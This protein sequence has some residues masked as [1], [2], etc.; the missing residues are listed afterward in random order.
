MRLNSGAI[1]RARLLRGWLRRELAQQAGV[2]VGSV[3][4]ACRSGDCGLT[5]GR[6]IASALGLAWQDIV[7][8]DS[9][10]TADAA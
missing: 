6:K 10:S 3:Q 1:E 2:S 4:R 7:I 5:A 8:I 9:P